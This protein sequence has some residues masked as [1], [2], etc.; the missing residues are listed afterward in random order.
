MLIHAISP[1]WY[2]RD[3]WKCFLNARMWPEDAEFPE[4]SYEEYN[5]LKEKLCIDG[6]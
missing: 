6:V 3:G 5:K 2:Y 1:T 4:F